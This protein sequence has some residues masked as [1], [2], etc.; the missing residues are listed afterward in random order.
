MLI[1]RNHTK[2]N[3]ETLNILLFYC[4]NTVF[5]AIISATL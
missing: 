3:L 1:D 2:H 4:T 5:R